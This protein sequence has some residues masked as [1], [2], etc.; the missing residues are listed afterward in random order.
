MKMN[1]GFKLEHFIVDFG[2]VICTHGSQSG[3][4]KW[5]KRLAIERG[6]LAQTVFNLPEAKEALVGASSEDDVWQAVKIHYGLDANEVREF[7][8]DF[9]ADHC[10]QDPLVNLCIRLIKSGHRVVLASNFWTG[11]RSVIP[12]RFGIGLDTFTRAYFSCEIGVAKPNADFFCRL[13]ADLG[14]PVEACLFLDDEPANIASAE[15]LGLRSII[16]E[17]NSASVSK[18]CQAFKVR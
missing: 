6:L 5:E 14:A 3:R 10:I 1:R 7:C 15:R 4:Q 9:W 17:S 8:A 18:V 11:A 13:L 2:G 12:E 16:H